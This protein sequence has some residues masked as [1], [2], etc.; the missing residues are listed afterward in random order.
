MKDAEQRM[1]DPNSVARS[2]SGVLYPAGL[3]LASVVVPVIVGQVAHGQGRFDPTTMISIAAGG[4][5]CALVSEC[6]VRRQLHL[7]REGVEVE[8]LIESM[9]CVSRKNDRWWA[10]YTFRTL[11]GQWTKGSSMVSSLD[12][13][14]LE[15]G[16]AVTVL[17]DAQAPKRSRIVNAMWAV[18]WEE[19]T[20]SKS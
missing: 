9:F 6:E 14:A 3:L 16:S 15:R 1:I 8:G 20:V 4:F 17:Y 5:L 10:R 13:A 12:A 7:A 18:T 2:M 19:E 11:E